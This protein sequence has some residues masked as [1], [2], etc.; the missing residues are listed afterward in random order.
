MLR[1][2]CLIL[3]WH[4]LS[5]PH[6]CVSLNVAGRGVECL[7]CAQMIFNLV[8]P[9]EWPPDGNELLTRVTVGYFCSC[10]FICIFN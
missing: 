9:A 2:V 3:S 1:H 8:E 5:I 6:N 4:S 10:M 7:L